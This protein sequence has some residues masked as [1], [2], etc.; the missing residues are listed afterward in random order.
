VGSL[1][2]VL[3][4][5][6]AGYIGS[7]VSRTLLARGHGVLVLDNLAEGHRSALDPKAIFLRGDLGDGTSLSRI[8]QDYPVEAV[9]HLAAY[10]LVGES[11]QIPGKYY[12]NNVSNGVVLLEAMKKFGVDK[13]VFSSTAAVYGDPLSTPIKES[14]STR[15][16]NPYG[17]SKLIFEQILEW[18]ARSYGL[19]YVTF[20]YFNAAGASDRLGEDHDPETHL[21]PLILRRALR[22]REGLSGERDVPPLTVFGLDYPT[23]DGSCIRDYIHIED[24]A[25]GHVLALEKIDEIGQGTYNLGNGQGFSVLEVIRAAEAILGSPIPFQKGSRRPGDP[26][27]LVASSD[28]ARQDLGWQPRYP[29]LKSIITSAWRWHQQF[30]EGYQD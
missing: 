20:R 27:V 15:P 6:G 5:G 26:A 22:I 24:L 18:Y 30:P 9:L 28:R 1:G 21:I 2:T 16:V 10:C 14:H 3:V 12:A 8:F 11:I 4:T 25:M 7:V 23:P 29:E 13:I 17:H 19:K